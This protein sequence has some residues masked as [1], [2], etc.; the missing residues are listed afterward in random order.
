MTIQNI[1]IEVLYPP[2]QRARTTQNRHVVHRK[3]IWQ[4]NAVLCGIMWRQ[5]WM[6]D[7][8]NSEQVSESGIHVISS[9]PIG[10]Q[11]TYPNGVR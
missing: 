7:I 3:S 11:D 5:R 1:L 6:W 10:I 4:G 8:F 2:S 9:Q